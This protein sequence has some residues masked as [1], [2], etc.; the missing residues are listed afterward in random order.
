MAEAIGLIS[1]ALTIA[2]VALG[3]G[4]A[5]LKLRRLC[6]L[7]K[8]LPSNILDLTHRLECLDPSLLE[9]ESIFDSYQIEKTSY[10]ELALKRT[11]AYCRVA[12]N[13][14]N[15]LVKELS[16][17]IDGHKHKN[18]ATRFRLLLKKDTL[19][20]LED[21]LGS[22]VNMLSLVQQTYLIV[23][24]RAQPDIIARKL[25]AYTDW[26]ND[27]HYR[28]TTKRNV[29]PSQNETA[30]GARYDNCG[31]TLSGPPN[32]IAA[33]TQRLTS[34]SITL[35]VPRW[36]SWKVWEICC[37]RAVGNWTFS[38][39]SYSTRPS[40]SQVFQ[41]ARHGSP[42]SL[43]QLFDTGLA[44]PYDRTVDGETLIHEAARG[45]N[46]DTTR[47]L[48]GTCWNSLEADNYGLYPF[49]KILFSECDE[50]E[51][52]RFAK[53]M[54]SDR[55]FG[56]EFFILSN[57][58]DSTYRNTRRTHSDEISSTKFESQISKW[59]LYCFRSPWLLRT[60]M[61]PGW[62]TDTRNTFE[63]KAMATAQ[64]LM[65]AAATLGG[66]ICPYPCRKCRS[67][68][69]DWETWAASTKKALKYTPDVHVTQSLWI[70]GPENK[71]LTAFTR[72]LFHS[73]NYTTHRRTEQWWARH[74]M[75]ELRIWLR[76]LKEEGFDLVRY[77]RRELE[78]LY[79]G[80]IYRDFDVAVSYPRR[81]NEPYLYYRTPFRLIGFTYGPNPE[82]WVIYLSE[83]T[84]LFA[85]EFWGMISNPQLNI[86]GSWVDD[87]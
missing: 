35:Q 8:D 86:P 30:D 49:A 55:N 7:I 69:F 10:S 71:R 82:D 84:D 60:M 41:V 63:R 31:S 77:G 3:I 11:V 13:D 51:A 26:N 25:S 34:C 76:T 87:N 47:Y 6:A 29:H 70:C 23:L 56:T 44:S 83:P 12:F 39:R 27:F 61:Q 62:P 48:M 33:V 46:I 28:R 81:Q 37:T 58:N 2:E 50:K 16:L 79:G 18:H 15:N 5:I 59:A 68:S 74:F 17:S 20:K 45:L 36:I 22:A 54:A 78:M 4:D 9:I 67:H 14:L 38:L 21:R 72:L 73:L 85:G 57:H 53:T 1:A 65:I 66:S 32:N 42:A 52:E 43:R 75:G 80:E 64:P 24:T 40:D 19:R